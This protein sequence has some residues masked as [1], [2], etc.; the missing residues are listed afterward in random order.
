MG[1]HLALLLLLF[2][3]RR[4]HDLTLLHTG[5]GGMI[6]S[7][8]QVTFQPKFGS[9][10]DGKGDASFVQSQQTFYTNPC[11]S[12]NVPAVTRQYLRLTKAVRN[13][14]AALFLSVRDGHPPA[15]VG[16]IRGWVKSLLEQAG[17][18]ASAGSTRAA[19]ATSACLSGCKLQDVLQNG[20]WRHESTM[21]RHYLRPSHQ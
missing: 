3:G 15:S 8:K 11:W 18:T 2:G 9:K 13:D 14:S 5:R 19:V 16:V 6:L 4:V 10:T 21:R 20:N 1:R 17:V 12:V 7:S